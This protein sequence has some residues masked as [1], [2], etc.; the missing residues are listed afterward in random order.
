MHTN[1]FILL[2]IRINLDVIALKLDIRKAYN[3]IEW[4]FLKATMGKMG[5]SDK[6][7]SLVM[8]FVR[9]TSISVLINGIPGNVFSP[10]RGIRYGDPLSPYLF[11]IYAQALSAK[12]EKKRD[13]RKA[14]GLE[15]LYVYL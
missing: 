1:L 10:Q 15:S 6:W 8:N 13:V 7:L 3:R 12:L 14:T 2:G 9:S 4:D 11:V 5:F